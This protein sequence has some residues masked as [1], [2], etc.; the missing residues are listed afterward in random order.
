MVARATRP[1]V[2]KVRG[3]R[4]LAPGTLPVWAVLGAKLAAQSRSPP[5][6]VHT[7]AARRK[8]AIENPVR[9]VGCPA[10]DHGATTTVTREE[11]A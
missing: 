1:S 11:S 4:L 2:R 9:R 5:T 10:A 8:R 7:G 3:V 6:L